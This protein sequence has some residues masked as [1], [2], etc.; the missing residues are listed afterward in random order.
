MPFR[1]GQERGRKGWYVFV[2]RPKTHRPRRGG[3][4]VRR[5]G[6]DT[7]EEALRNALRIE[8]ELVQ[9]WAADEPLNPFQAALRASQELGVC[10][11]EALDSEL[12]DQG[13][14]R[15]SLCLRFIYEP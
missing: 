3:K 2:D 7:R 15:R 11:D 9:Q 1:V 4:T 8:A 14:N 10:L 6:G 5:K 13:R 12:R